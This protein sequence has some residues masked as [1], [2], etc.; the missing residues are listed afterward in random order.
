MD[1]PPQP[2]RTRSRVGWSRSQEPRRDLYRPPPPVTLRNI[3]M[4]KARRA[5]C[6]RGGYSVWGWP[7]TPV[8]AGRRRCRSGGVGGGL[9]LMRPRCGAAVVAGTGGGT[10]GRGDRLREIGAVRVGGQGCRGWTVRAQVIGLVG[11]RGRGSGTRTTDPLSPARSMTVGGCP[12]PVNTAS[13][14]RAGVK[15]EVRRHLTCRRSGPRLR[16]HDF[17][18]WRRQSRMASLGREAR[19]SVATSVLCI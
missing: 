1:S 8:R 4:G 13:R 12:W 19:S 3:A 18:R 11:C 16:H 17:R 6:G 2:A 7:C 9:C 10:E 5:V 15:V 14:R